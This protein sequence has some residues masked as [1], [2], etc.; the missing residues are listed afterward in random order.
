MPN[1]TRERALRALARHA[2][3]LLEVELVELGHGLD[4]TAFVAGDVVLRVAEDRRV[5]RE[6]RLLEC[7]AGHVSV[8]IPVPRFADEEAGVLGYGR[9]PGVPLLGRNP[10]QGA[11]RRLGEF[12]R[13]LHGINPATVAELIPVQDADPD[14]WLDELKG[15][16]ELVRM[17]RVGRPEP[18]CQRVVA[19]ADL[20][21]EHILELDGTLTGVI[22]WSDAAVT[23]P[24]LD[25]ARLYRDFGPPLLGELLEAYGPLPNAMPRIEFFARCAALEDL[26]YGEA[27]GQEAYVFNARRSFAWLFPKH[28]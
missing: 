7:V 15:P 8:A 28:G 10:P 25:F 27:T 18:S 20:G 2:P 9:I 19:H 24:A 1:V 16:P 21:A 26:A 13:D 6:A 14:E 22:D 5:S 3:D 12:L 17:T 23:D 4:S 11:A